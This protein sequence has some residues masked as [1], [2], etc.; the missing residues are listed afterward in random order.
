MGSRRSAA[1]PATQATG[2]D[3]DMHWPIRLL[4]VAAA[5]ALLPAPSRADDRS[6]CAA[7]QGTL[8][9]G[10]VTAPPTFAS[11]R[12][13]QGIPLSHTHIR[14]RADG[15]GKAYDVAVDDVF[16]AGYQPQRAAVPPPLDTIVAGQRLEACGLLYPGGIHWVHTNCGSTPSA[17][18]PNGWLKIV[19]AAGVAGPNLEASTRYCYLW[20]ARATAIRHRR[21]RFSTSP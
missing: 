15:D 14:I 1:D 17:R 19:D 3:R 9:T 10:V 13:V 4:V 6:D 12:S 8:L 16:A 2:Y 11:G 21:H 5:S 7:G 18:D 20:P